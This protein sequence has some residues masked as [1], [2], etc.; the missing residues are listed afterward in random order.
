M[1]STDRALAHL[2]LIRSKAQ[3]A[4]HKSDPKEALRE[5]SEAIAQLVTVLEHMHRTTLE[6]G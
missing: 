2:S 5:L 1:V 4:V 3:T 6:K